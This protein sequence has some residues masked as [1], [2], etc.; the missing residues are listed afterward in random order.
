LI[1]ERDGQK[2]KS[3]QVAETEEGRDASPGAAQD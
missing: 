3:H 2:E 1:E